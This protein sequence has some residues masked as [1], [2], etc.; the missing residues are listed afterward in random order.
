MI[1]DAL[2]LARRRLYTGRLEL[3][4]NPHPR[5][6]LSCKVQLS[7]GN[8]SV[9]SVRRSTEIFLTSP[10]HCLPSSRPDFA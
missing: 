7:F 9:N 8:L 3:P 1:T 6:F 2:S 5:P 4:R 10:L